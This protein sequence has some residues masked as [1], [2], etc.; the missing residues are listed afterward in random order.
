MTHPPVDVGVLDVLDHLPVN[1]PGKPWHGQAAAVK[2]NVRPWAVYLSRDKHD[3]TCCLT[4]LHGSDRFL[5]LGPDLALL[6][7][8]KACS[9]WLVAPDL[10]PVLDVLVRV[11]QVAGLVPHGVAEPEAA[12]VEHQHAQAR[13]REG[14]GVRLQAERLGAA[15]QRGQSSRAARGCTALR[16][17]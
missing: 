10:L 12:V 3:S 14:R 1:R 5:L 15:G 8:Q 2:C 13:R 6:M 4:C 9:C 11:W 16:Q 17:V 7:T